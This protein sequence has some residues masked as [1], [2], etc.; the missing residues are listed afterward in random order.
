MPYAD[1]DYPAD[2][3]PGARPARSFVH[4]GNN[5]WSLLSAEDR[6]WHWSV[7]GV[8]LD[9]WL[10]LRGAEPL[11]ARVPV[12]AYGS[13]ANPAKIGWLRTALGLTGPVV[14]LRVRCTGLAAVWATHLR[15]RDNQRPA[16]L[17]AEPGRVEWHAVWLAT[18]AQ[19]RVLDVCEGRGERYRLVR[20]ATGTVTAE[21][22]TDLA[23]VLAYTAAGDL[24]A[25]LLVDGLPVRCADLP[26]AEAMFLTGE[27]GHDGLTVEPIVGA[28]VAGDWTYLLQTGRM[29]EPVSWS[30]TGHAG[31]VAG[32]TWPNA[33][34]R[35]LAVLAHDHGEEIA[36]YG[37]VAEE[38]VAA[39]AVVVGSDMAGHG[40]SAGERGLITDFEQVVADLA[41]VIDQQ[42]AGLPMVLIGHAIGGMVV[43]RYTQ[44]YPDR[45]AALVLSA[46]VLGPWEALDLLSEQDI[47]AGSFRRETLRAIEECLSTIDFDHPLGDDLPALWL[48]GDDDTLVPVADTRAGMDRIRGLRFEERI[49]PGVGHDLLRG[50]GSSVALADITEFARRTVQDSGSATAPSATAS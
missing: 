14:V 43:V 6:P 2:P 16:T 27:Q 32:L 33:D 18:P 25:P 47:P 15:V 41:L 37:P 11:A 21:D 5:C 24:R 49:Y 29:V 12:L 3:Y 8:E 26:Q 30:L 36:G 28:P 50:A 48:H 44:R 4:E 22:G 34:A 42:P 45:V 13:N 17:T 38:L 46:P 35:W 1:V 40:R 9:D 23:G 20:L 7:D 39:G 19:V 10:T 31:E